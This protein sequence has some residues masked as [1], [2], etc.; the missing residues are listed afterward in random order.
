MVLLVLLTAGE[1]AE[2]EGSAVPHR[3]LEVSAVPEGVTHVFVVRALGVED[4]V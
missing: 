3:M 4:V 1:E 2:L